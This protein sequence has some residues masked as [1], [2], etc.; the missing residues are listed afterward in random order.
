ML[1]AKVWAP[2][3]YNLFNF[4]KIQ[5]YDRFLCAN[6]PIS[7]LFLPIKLTGIYKGPSIDSLGKQ[8]P[9]TLRT[10]LCAQRC[11]HGETAA[12]MNRDKTRTRSTQGP[13]GTSQE[14]TFPSVI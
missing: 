11:P 9:L 8:S 13:T 3:F 4:C 14:N 12:V 5:T 10:S 6:I 7:P 2:F 1:L